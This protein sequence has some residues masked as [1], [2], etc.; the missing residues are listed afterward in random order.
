MAYLYRQSVMNKDSWNGVAKLRP[1]PPKASLLPPNPTPDVTNLS[2][3]PESNSSSSSA[4]EQ[5][6]NVELPSDSET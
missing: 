3:T 1:L 6:V 5:A 4:G 2:A